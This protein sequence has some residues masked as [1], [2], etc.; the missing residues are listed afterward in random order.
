M[1]LAALIF[2]AVSACA[3]VPLIDQEC[4]ESLSDYYMNNK[5][6][7]CN[8][9][10]EP[11]RLFKNMYVVRAQGNNITTVYIGEVDGDGYCLVHHHPYYGSINGKGATSFCTFGSGTLDACIWEDK[12]SS[13]VLQLRSENPS[14]CRGISWERLEG[15]FEQAKFKFVRMTESNDDGY[16][17]AAERVAASRKKIFSF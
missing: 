9:S 14:G 2:S 7:Y 1:R 11:P 5:K 8:Y 13:V 17:E 6:P 3:T 15:T 4:Y 12:D 16:L 10:E